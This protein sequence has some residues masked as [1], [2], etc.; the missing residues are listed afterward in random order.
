[1]NHERIVTYQL[2]LDKDYFENN[3]IQ[4]MS[5]ILCKQCFFIFTLNYKFNYL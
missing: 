3:V 5:I 4:E 1:M 2:P